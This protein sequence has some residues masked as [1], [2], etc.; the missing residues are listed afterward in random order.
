VGGPKKETSSY[1]SLI[2]RRKK[3]EKKKIIIPPQIE[4]EMIE[5]GTFRGK[6]DAVFERKRKS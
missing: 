5:G 2:K 6:T 4:K 1:S 3:G